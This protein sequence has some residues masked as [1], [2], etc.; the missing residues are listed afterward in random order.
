MLYRPHPLLSEGQE[1]RVLQVLKCAMHVYERLPVYFPVIS[2]EVAGYYTPSCHEIAHAYGQVFGLEVC[3]GEL[4]Y[5]DRH[6]L[7]PT[8]LFRQESI[9]ITCKFIKH[10]WLEF[11][12]EDRRF[13][14]DIFP[15]SRVSMSPILL[16]HPHP[17]YYVPDESKHRGRLEHVFETEKFKWNVELLAKYMKNL[18]SA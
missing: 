3:D 9:D 12:A 2:D 14:L 15:E 1:G 7:I 6:Q 5:I 10:S 11:E 4:A 16:P 17:A 18:A 8:K 13:I